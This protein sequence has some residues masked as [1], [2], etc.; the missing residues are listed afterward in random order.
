MSEELKE[1][2]A[3]LAAESE[4]TEEQTQE[5]QTEVATPEDEAGKPET[6]EA[7]Q[8]EGEDDED[9][10][11]E[12]ERPR[13]K[14]RSERL[15]RQNERLQA[16][17]AAL[18]SGS[19]SPAVQDQA[20]LDALIAQKVGEPPKEADYPNDWFAFER[21]MNAYEA[22]KRVVARQV[23]EQVQQAQTAQASRYR[24][25]AEDYQ[26]HLAE[27]AKHVPDLMKVLSAST[28]KPTPMVE[29]LLLEAGE[30]AP[31]VVYNLAQNPKLAARLNA[32]PALEAAREIGRIEGR[33]SIPKPKSATSASPPMS[34]PRGSAAPSSDEAKMNSWLKKT[35]GG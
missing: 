33:V 25:L 24:E 19:A 22:D 14:S 32:M 15:R 35:Y 10:K 27:T 1:L 11:G 30:K 23:R 17:I 29:M 16:E 2:L 28:Y 9:D 7:E 20:G 31:L 18:K 26:E 6:G 5:Q 8:A 3:P 12:D 34:T 13:K 4:R 21:A